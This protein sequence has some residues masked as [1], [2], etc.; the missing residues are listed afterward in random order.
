MTG[1]EFWHWLAFGGVLLII[2]A[3]AP[4]FVFIW[5]GASAAL[6]G[7]LLFLMPD[8]AWQTQLLAFSAFAVVSVAGWLLLRRKR[9]VPTDQ[10]ALNRR[11]EQYVGRICTLVE[12]IEGGRFKL[13]AIRKKGWKLGGRIA[14][15]GVS[16]LRMCRS[17]GELGSVPFQPA[18]IRVGESATA[19]RLLE[20]L[21]DDPSDQKDRGDL[22]EQERREAEGEREDD[23]HH[24]EHDPGSDDGREANGEEGE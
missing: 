16:S 5:L 17:G 22:E 23:P 14:L 6:V 13:P 4:G 9:P 2:E 8:L 24:A 21:H 7:G 12:A 19:T 10:P 18:A 11:S 3:F 20:D 1:V 15:I